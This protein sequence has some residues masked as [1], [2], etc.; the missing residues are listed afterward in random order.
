VESLFAYI[1]VRVVGFRITF[2]NSIIQREAMVLNIKIIDLGESSSI[3]AQAK[4][5][6]LVAASARDFSSIAS[7]D[8]GDLVVHVKRY[9]RDGN[10]MKFS[11]TA[12]LIAGGLH[13]KSESHSWTLNIALREALDA[14]KGQWAHNRGRTISLHKDKKLVEKNKLF[15][16]R[17]Y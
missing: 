9:E 7:V 2:V 14:L 12:R 1:N 5:K 15:R 13:F 8:D 4:A 3:L 17:S 11:V 6:D 10:R 16:R